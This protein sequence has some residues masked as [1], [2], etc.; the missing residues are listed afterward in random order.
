MRGT[1]KTEG[2]GRERECLRQG[3]QRGL[4]MATGNPGAQWSQET[5]MQGDRFLGQG[6]SASPWKN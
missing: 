1:M 6:H 2:L 4:Y 3:G 5:E